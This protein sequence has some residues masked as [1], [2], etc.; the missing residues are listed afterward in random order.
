MQQK[1]DGVDDDQSYR[2]EYLPAVLR[3]DDALPAKGISDI[4]RMGQGVTYLSWY[5]S[6]MNSC[7]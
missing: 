5:R 7:S 3:S 6:R 4:Y 1:N 2:R